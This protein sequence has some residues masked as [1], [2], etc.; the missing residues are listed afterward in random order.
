MK[1]AAVAMSEIIAILKDLAP[2]ERTRVI[3][4]ISVFFEASVPPPRLRQ[5][6]APTGLGNTAR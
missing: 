3:S 2:D 1:D 4:A 5:D 6:Y